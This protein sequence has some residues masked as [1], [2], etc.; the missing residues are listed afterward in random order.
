MD[1]SDTLR[2]AHFTCRQTCSRRAATGALAAAALLLAA[3]P[4]FAQDTGRDAPASEPYLRQGLQAEKAGQPEKALEIWLQG[5]A[6]ADPDPRIGFNFIRVVTADSLAGYFEFASL[7]YDWGLQVKEWVPHF[8]EAMEAEIERL[9][10]LL[11]D[12]TYREWQR[13]H[14]QADPSL[15]RRIAGWWTLRDAA[16]LTP[17][18]ERLLEHWERIAYAREHYNR[19]SD[20]AY[21]TD[22]RGPVYVRYGPPDLVRS[23]QLQFLSARADA[24]ITDIW[25]QAMVHPDPSEV[26]SQDVAKIVKE[27]RS[28]Y[29]FPEYEV[30]VYRDLRV[31]Q[32]ESTIYMFG[33]DGEIGGYTLI[34]QVEDFIPNAAFSMGNQSARHRNIAVFDKPGD[35]IRAGLILQLMY[36]DQLAAYD[37]YFGSMLERI[38]SRALQR[39]QV[40]IGLMQEMKTAARAELVEG[41]RRAPREESGY[42]ERM[43][44]IPIEIH[45]YRL[46]DS[47]DNPYLATFVLSTPRQAFWY[48]Y[49][50]NYTGGETDSADV[51]AQQRHLRHYRL[52]HGFQAYGPEG[53][54]LGQAR[55]NPDIATGADARSRSVLTVPHVSAETR[56]VFSAELR[57]NDPDSEYPVQTTFPP[58][59][60]GAG[61]AIVSQPP[62]LDSLGQPLAMG[63]LIV[64]YDL[65]A[66]A[67]AEA[68]FPFTVAHEHKIP[69]D[70]ELVLHF[71]V[72]N[73]PQDPDGVA[74]FTLDY[75]VRPD[76]S[77]LLGWSKARA[78]E[79]TVSLNLE[80]EGTAYREDL[81]I[82]TAGL[83]PGSYVMEVTARKEGTPRSTTRTFEFE[84]TD[85]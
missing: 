58:E 81:Q 31:D 68:L 42:E 8:A 34:E 25:A 75:Q 11:S 22:E 78:E 36:Y 9:E 43:L 24:W 17:R 67:P 62:R 19:G 66:D 21:G 60:R 1:A 35:Q 54:L 20:S 41:R 38:E 73:L 4:A 84:V 71:E 7:M 6:M 23:G 51:A 29:T 83:E 33:T 12:G 72:Y 64:G 32:N 70:R 82:Q 56:Q 77:G 48:D 13:L 55:D 79:L 28:Y 26:R 50:R 44:D 85:Q 16:P 3:L 14:R 30:W 27:V 57:N 76:E 15:Y 37:S 69:R 2:N 5:K 80:T 39:G 18:N 52:M 40:S 46:R 65:R 45:Q 47:R 61:K 10:P 59:L 49:L 53:E 63:D 74:R